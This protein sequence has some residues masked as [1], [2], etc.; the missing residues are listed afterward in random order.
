VFEDLVDTHRV[1]VVLEVPDQ[2]LR[3][4]LVALAREA[5]LEPEG[6][7]DAEEADGSIGKPEDGDAGEDCKLRG[8]ATFHIEQKIEV[9]VDRTELDAAGGLVFKQELY[10]SRKKDA[11]PPKTRRAC[12]TQSERSLWLIGRDARAVLEEAVKCADLPPGRFEIA[13]VYFV[14]RFEEMERMRYAADPWLV[15]IRLKKIP[16]KCRGQ[17]FTNAKEDLARISI[18]PF[19]QKLK[20]LKLEPLKGGVGE[21]HPFRF[22]EPPPDLYDFITGPVRDLVPQ[23]EVAPRSLPLSVPCA[24]GGGGAPWAGINPPFNEPS[25]LSDQRTMLGLINAEAM[26]SRVTQ[27]ATQVKIFLVDCGVFQPPAAGVLDSELVLNVN[28]SRLMDVIDAS[29]GT[30]QVGCTPFNGDPHG[31][32][33]AGIIGAL[34]RSTGMAGI[35]GSGRLQTNISMISLRCGSVNNICD[36]LTYAAQNAG[37]AKCVVVFGIDALFIYAVSLLCPAFAGEAAKFETALATAYTNDLFLVLPAGN[38]DYNVTGS[39]TAIF[40]TPP[41]VTGAVV[42]AATNAGGTCR[43]DDPSAAVHMASRVG[44]AIDF[45]APGAGIFTSSNSLT[46]SYERVTGTS[47]AAAHVGGIAA[48]VRYMQPVNSRPAD[49]KDKL[50]RSFTIL[51]GPGTSLTEVGLGR[52]DGAQALT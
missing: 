16:G 19:L 36:A 35:T 25:Y 22:T 30:F 39:L 49:V 20:E 28:M 9:T 32:Q 43:L 23:L 29:T 37:G 44:S 5:G 13:S 3:K 48:L 50:R 4:H 45:A 42:V 34:W 24:A 11:A 26:W 51:S 2:A 6:A 8:T 38:F 15:D 46:N 33:M 10:L 47:F 14:P 52:I 18:E 7:Y 12:V 1:L 21:W 40:A 41:D 27:Q 31:T 17:V